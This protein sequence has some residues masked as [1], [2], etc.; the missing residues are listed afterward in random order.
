MTFT[1]ETMVGPLPHGPCPTIGPMAHA[2]PSAMIV[3]CEQPPP[4]MVGFICSAPFCYAMDS[5]PTCGWPSSELSTPSLCPLSEI[6][7]QVHG[8][9]G[10]IRQGNEGLH[11]HG[12]ARDNGSWLQ[13]WQPNT[14]MNLHNHSAIA[15]KLSNGDSNI[16]CHQNSH[17]F[18]M[19]F[20]MFL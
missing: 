17:A 16:A 13:Q 8:R 3:C 7:P 10:Q 18:A 5:L 2:L 1:A 19:K 20:L 9:Q 4:Q 6:L 15:Y 12:E 14:H 11:I